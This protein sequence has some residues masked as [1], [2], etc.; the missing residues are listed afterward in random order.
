MTAKIL[1]ALI[2]SSVVAGTAAGA[3]YGVT[4]W[5]PEGATREAVERYVTAPGQ[6]V[7]A[8]LKDDKAARRKVEEG[9]ER[10]EEAGLDLS[11]LKDPAL[12]AELAKGAA[13]AR[14]EARRLMHLYSVGSWAGIGF[15]LCLAMTL[16][17]GVRSIGA[18]LALGF[19]VT[20]T[21]VFLQGALVLGGM[22]ALR[23]LGG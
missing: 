20:L 3:S 4:H 6:E 13:R 15:V 22:L 1:H 23:K 9:K 5:V 2:A 19:K 10:L 18:A 17:F 21:L 8:R 14:E 7:Y 16:L 12:R 11:R